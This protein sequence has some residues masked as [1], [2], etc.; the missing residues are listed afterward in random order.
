MSL[1]LEDTY[2]PRSKTEKPIDLP[3][4]AFQPQVADDGLP[5]KCDW[6]AVFF[7][8]LNSGARWK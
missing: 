2:F 8:M 3:I 7:D 6:A 1:R 4:Y 5:N